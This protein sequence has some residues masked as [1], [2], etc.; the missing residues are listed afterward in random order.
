MIGIS[1]FI[2]ECATTLFFGVPAATIVALPC[3]WMRSLRSFVH[4]IIAP[5][6]EVPAGGAFVS[7]SVMDR[8]IPSRAFRREST[9]HW[10]RLS[11]GAQ[12]VGCTIWQTGAHTSPGERVLGWSNATRAPWGSTGHPNDA[13]LRNRDK[14]IA[15]KEAFERIAALCPE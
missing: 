8:R 6:G 14:T 7:G 11:A 10:S 5:H 2:L 13:L 1:I 9:H 15:E 4:E 3:P 12:Q